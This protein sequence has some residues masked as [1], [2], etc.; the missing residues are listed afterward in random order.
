MLSVLRAVREERRHS[1]DAIADVLRM[2]REL[3][4]AERGEVA[5]LA[6]GILRRQR[7]LDFALAPLLPERWSEDKL[8]FARLLA[9][10]VLLA[11]VP[12]ENARALSPRIDWRALFGYPDRLRGLSDPIE[13][14]S[15]EG[16]LPRWLVERLGRDLGPREA[17]AL[18]LSWHLAPPQTLRANRVKSTR[19]ELQKAL[20]AKN[21][22]TRPTALSSDG[23][24]LETK[25]SP[26]RLP[27]FL[28]GL[29][30]VQDEG[31]QLV[32]ELVAPPPGG[33]VIDACAG[34]GG[35]TLH[36][37][38]LLSGSGQV[39]AVGVGPK[40]KRSL[41]ELRRRARRAGLHNVRVLEAPEEGELPPPLA[42]L[43]ARADR[44]LVD[45]P[46]SGLGVLRRNPEIKDR[47]EEADIHRLASLQLSILT[48]FAGLVRPGGRLI[49]ATCSV[50]AEENEQVV[51]A[52]LA[53]HP[54]FA[55]TPAKEV[56]GRERGE[57]M[58]DGTYLK[59]YPHRQS[60]DGFFG[61]AMRRGAR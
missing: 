57:R 5:E 12:P 35:K 26:F 60:T 49:Y 8:D 19:A 36:L 53:T 17:H 21:V 11:Q 10:R 6:Y 22:V 1:A 38:S 29:F 25:C 30:E 14:L 4:E 39:L 31:S 50:L 52:F 28:E 46:C 58:G 56:L 2:A 44:V 20:R 13:R 18:A 32:S 45:A 7:L 47:L 33:L 48:R 23:L 15:I 43:H 40:T 51:K 27:A 59:V 24:V 41:D 37:A 61:A 54:E 55:I 34:T 3:H 42:R 9:H 16:S